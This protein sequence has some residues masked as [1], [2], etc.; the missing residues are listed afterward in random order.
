MLRSTSCRKPSGALWYP[1]HATWPDAASVPEKL[2]ISQ[3]QTDAR[4]KVSPKPR[5]ARSEDRDGSSFQATCQGEGS[6]A[7][8]VAFSFARIVKDSLVAND[9]VSSAMH[10]AVP[11][12][13][14]LPSGP[15]QGQCGMPN[16]ERHL[17][18]RWPSTA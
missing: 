6:R 5:A 3:S 10:D 8:T 13:R 1:A 11:H 12:A 2:P 9:A 4:P 16:A 15:G 18:G 14:K 7:K 17:E